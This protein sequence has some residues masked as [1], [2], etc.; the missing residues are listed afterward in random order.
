MKMSKTEEKY[1]VKLADRKW[2]NYNTAPVVCRDSKT[3]RDLHRDNVG[4]YFLHTPNMTGVKSITPLT[5]SEAKD[6]VARDGTAE[7]YQKLFMVPL[8]TQKSIRLEGQD[9][10]CLEFL[11]NAYGMSGNE[12]I[13]RLIRAEYRRQKK[14][15]YNKT[16]YDKS[17]LSDM[18]KPLTADE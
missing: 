12:I 18:D 10:V 4:K 14:S 2:Y 5:L 1:G 6:I 11:C 7:Q 17:K 3:G 13:R 9:A 16:A 15:E 8:G